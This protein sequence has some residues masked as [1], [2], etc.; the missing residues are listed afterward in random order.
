MNGEVE[1]WKREVGGGWR[2][3]DVVLLWFVVTQI[4]TVVVSSLLLFLLML[5][6]EAI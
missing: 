3:E 2:F 4:F 1:N 5:F 6:S